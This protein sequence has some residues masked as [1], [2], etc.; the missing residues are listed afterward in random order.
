VQPP[1]V[2]STDTTCSDGPIPA[3]SVLMAV[4]NGEEFLDQAIASIHSQ[5]LRDLELIVVD[6]GS[7][8]ATPAMLAG[9]AERDPRI[10]V[11]QLARPGLARS[12]NFAAGMARGPLYARLDADDIAEPKRLERQRAALIADA[13][14][15]AIGSNASLIDHRGRHLGEVRRAA[16]RQAV[17]Q[18]LARG[19]PFVHSTM[20]FRRSLFEQVG[21]YRDGLRATEDLDLW[22]RMEEISELD[23]L[24]DL[25][26]RYRLHSRSMMGR[27]RIRVALAETCARAATVARRTG[28]AEPFAS[29]RP[30]LRR[31]LLLLEVDRTAFRRQFRERARRQRID[32]LY[33][34]LPLPSWLKASLRTALMAL[35]LKALYGWLLAQGR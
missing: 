32:L 29:G 16:G 33:L 10:R 6:N 19:N 17:R 35:G 3:V 5:S 1:S 25:L 21:G 8:D 14:L 2:A 12:L 31:A 9:W 7:R 22:L 30:Q 24:P 23:L 34:L 20:M 26:V 15:G 4:R 11:V 28:K 13:T 18:F 27:Q